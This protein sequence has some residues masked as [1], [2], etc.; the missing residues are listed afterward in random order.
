MSAA[1]KMADGRSAAELAALRTRWETQTEE[2]I[3]TRSAAESAGQVRYEF[4]PILRQDMWPRHYT[5]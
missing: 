3:S 1:A 4:R 2:L 5:E